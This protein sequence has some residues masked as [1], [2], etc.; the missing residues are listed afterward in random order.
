MKQRLFLLPALILFSCLQLTAQD[1]PEGTETKEPAEKNTIPMNMIKVNLTSLPLKQYA[2][3]YERVLSRKFSFAL[4][5]RV[6]PEST[7][8][9]KQAIL[10]AVGDDPDTRDVLETFQM[11]N[12]AITP[13]FRFYLSKRGYGRGFYLAPFY[14]YASYKTSQLEFDYD[15]GGGGTETIN[16][17]GKLTSH[18]G[19]LLLGAQWPLGKRLVLD[20]WILG[21][22]YG[23]GNGLFNGISSQ[24]MTP[25]EQDDLRTELEDLDIPLTNKKVVVTANGASLELD[26]P[27]GGIRAGFSLGIRF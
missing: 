14:R 8:P 3:Q 17:T 9:F 7:L 22:H 1:Q 21:P 18:T 20:W 6:M 24:T 5:V 13:E 15:D 23:T 4:G 27:W 2:L 19:G 25:A 12:L 16:M 10:D 11:S 26:G